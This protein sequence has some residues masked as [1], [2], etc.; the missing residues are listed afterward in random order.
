[1]QLTYKSFGAIVLAF[2][3][4]TKSS[5]QNFWELH[6]PDKD[7]AMFV[8]E[9]KRIETLDVSELLAKS[10]NKKILVLAEKSHSEGTLYVAK[11][12]VL[13]KLARETSFTCLVEGSIF[14]FYYHNAKQLHKSGKRLSAIYY[15]DVEF[16]GSLGN[17]LLD[18]LERQGLS[19][20]INILAFSYGIGNKPAIDMLHADLEKDATTNIEGLSIAIDRLFVKKVFDKDF[21]YFHRYTIYPKFL[22]SIKKA[23]DHFSSFYD[24]LLKK[25]HSLEEVK[26]L[27]MKQRMWI[28][29]SQY[30]Q[31]RFY[32]QSMDDV[33]MYEKNNFTEITKSSI[34]RDRFLYSNIAWYIKDYLPPNS[35]VVLSI[36][37]MHALKSVNFNNDTKKNGFYPDYE[38]VGMLINRDTLFK[39]NTY[40]TAIVSSGGYTG[41]NTLRIK[42][43]AAPQKNSIE[44]K[45]ADMGVDIGF[46]DLSNTKNLL[47]KKPF[48]MSPFFDDKYL[49]AE[50]SN[51]YDGFIYV[52]NVLPNI[53]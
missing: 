2:F 6:P 21:E 20:S 15:N 3:C 4:C 34:L 7:S 38:T 50:W 42:K 8:T 12:Y 22:D 37:A 43:I 49:K 13:E 30:F 36:S 5:A 35:K 44:K 29:V 32:E 45:I 48:S 46:Y 52:K 27:K 23:T 14:E 51:Y 28:C 11:N 9:R 39:E 19:D 24:I 31:N 16:R 53:W 33:K 41:I 10:R 17:S 25:K 18:T 1:M 26:S 40:T 47:F